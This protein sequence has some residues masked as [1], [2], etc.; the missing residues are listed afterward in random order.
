MQ[1][2]ASRRPAWG[3]TEFK[4]M[5]A[6]KHPLRSTVTLNRK[7]TIVRRGNDPRLNGAKRTV[8]VQ[9]A[10]D[11]KTII[12]PCVRR[13]F[14]IHPL[15]SIDFHIDFREDREVWPRKGTK[16]RLQSTHALK[17]I[18]VR[19]DRFN[20]ALA[21]NESSFIVYW[22]QTEKRWMAIHPVTDMRYTVSPPENRWDTR[23]CWKEYQ[24]DCFIS[25]T[26]CSYNNISSIEFM[27]S[28][29][30]WSLLPGVHI[31][32]KKTKKNKKIIFIFIIINKIINK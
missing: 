22:L 19:W 27:L 6:H 4:H 8:G 26:L 12:Q 14:T 29:Y 9:E 24:K 7:A 15:A 16:Y 17:R 2:K 10:A 1:L 30:F 21:S 5:H 3:V 25:K 20:T 23:R 32:A 18:R 11:Q 13:S 28:R 31:V